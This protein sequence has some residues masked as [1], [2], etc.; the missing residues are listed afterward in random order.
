MFDS[1]KF[2]IGEERRIKG[3]Q[4]L[5]RVDSAQETS[6]CVSQSTRFKH[7][8]KR[9]KSRTK[10]ILSPDWDNDRQSTL[11]RFEDSGERKEEYTEEVEAS[12]D[13]S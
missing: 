13:T 7:T 6:Q 8:N 2:V 3:I 12:V 11:T 1:L 10:N 4:S 5:G 9:L